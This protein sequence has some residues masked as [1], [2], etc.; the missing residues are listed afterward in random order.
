[1]V[2][3]LK[4]MTLLRLAVTI[5][6]HPLDDPPQIVDLRSISWG[7]ARPS[8][9]PTATDLA[10]LVDDRLRMN[11]STSVFYVSNAVLS[12]TNPYPPVSRP[13]SRFSDKTS[14]SVTNALVSRFHLH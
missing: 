12:V 5:L 14:Q 9:R 8:F 6:E 13:L 11:I 1:M 7:R 4:P 3:W 2:C 10:C